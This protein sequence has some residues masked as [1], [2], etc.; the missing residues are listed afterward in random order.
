MKFIQGGPGRFQISSEGNSAKIGL[1]L[2][3]SEGFKH[4][5]YGNHNPTR[6]LDQV[7]PGYVD[8]DNKPEQ[9]RR[10]DDSADSICNLKEAGTL[11]PGM[12]APDAPSKSTNN[13]VATSNNKGG[14]ARGTRNECK[15]LDA[16][17][18]KRGDLTVS[19]SSKPFDLISNMDNKPTTLFDEYCMVVTRKYSQDN[20]LESTTLKIQ[21]PFIVTA[22]RNII[23]Y[24]PDVPLDVSD[25]I[26]IGDP[27]AII[28]HY[29]HELA[30]YACQIA[31]ADENSL[32]TKL[33]I[34]YLLAY[35]RVCMGD[36]MDQCE[37]HLAKG[38]IKY[39]WLWMLYRPGTL[40]YSSGA[41]QL[42][43]F[44]RSEYVE[45]GGGHAFIVHCH[46]INYDGVSVGKEVRKVIFAQFSGPRELSWLDLLPLEYCDDV[47]GLK[48]RLTERGRV[49]LSLRGVHQRAHPEHG[50]VIVDC[51]TYQQRVFPKEMY[52]K[53]M[54]IESKSSC[55]CRVCSKKV[56][57]TKDDYDHEL[58]ELSEEEMMLCSATVYGF[59]L[60]HHKWK[61]FRVNDLAEI[62]WKTDA[63]RGLVMDDAQKKVILSLVTSRLFVEGKETGVVEGKGKGLV[64]LLHGTPGTG[65]TLTAECVC[66]HLRRPLYIVGGGEL[67]IKPADLERNLKDILAL[68]ARW[69]AITLIDEADI[70]L[71]QRSATDL[72][73]NSLVSVF[74]RELEYF[75]GI[76][77]LTTNRVERF[78]DAFTSRIHLA[79]QYPDLSR[80]MRRDVWAYSLA[81]FPAADVLVDVGPDSKD[82]DVLAREDLNGRVIS[83]AVRTA[84]ALADAEGEP[85]G[86]AHLKDVLGVYQKFNRRMLDGKSAVSG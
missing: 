2:R 51:K 35:L 37:A 45:C 36:D 80:A 40:V 25:V 64:V 70:F 73:R 57:Q 76:L 81:R 5:Y 85:L 84:K 67:G 15:T 78:D 65:K 58:R 29:R 13:N 38:L 22:L 55:V 16:R 28:Y 54:K 41:D 4:W 86:V 6:N 17:Y 14:L 33:H 72:A 62:D 82:L 50:R 21:S 75:T 23:K 20:K 79:L 53:R 46:V 18:D 7:F 10:D 31:G 9:N 44:E 60:K 12:K 47:D 27:P 11:P 30:T 63:I 68:S 69:N 66:E 3:I 83:Y 34:N 61:E 59:T 43:F 1:R 32:Q 42:Y 24:S 56:A 19:E 71:E 26:D 8:G 49:F 48:R 74:L 77:F 39:D 52:K